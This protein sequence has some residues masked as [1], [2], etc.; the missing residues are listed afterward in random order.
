M[1]IQDL[2]DVM[3]LAIERDRLYVKRNAFAAHDVIALL[4]L[5]QQRRDVQNPIITISPGPGFDAMREYALIELD[6]EIEALETKMRALGV[7][8]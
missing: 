6:G 1:K 5:P 8:V 7:K 2:Q 3:K 4:E